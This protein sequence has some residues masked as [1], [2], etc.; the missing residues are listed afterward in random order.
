MVL[1]PANVFPKTTARFPTFWDLMER[2]EL[3]ESI[4]LKSVLTSLV[5]NKAYLHKLV[6]FHLQVW[7]QLFPIQIFL[8]KTIFYIPP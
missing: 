8:K 1:N 2:C 3:Q 4:K 6:V 5:V 7:K